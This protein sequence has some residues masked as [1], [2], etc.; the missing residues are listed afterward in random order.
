[1]TDVFFALG[2]RLGL[3]TLVS[4]IDVLPRQIRWDAM[5]RAALRDEVL[6]AQAELTAAVVRDADPGADANALA[7]AW[8]ARNPALPAR[9]ATLREVCEG[10]PTLARMS[11]GLGVV[12]GLV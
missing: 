12:R 8:M 3:D 2:E 11:V 7:E 9:I 6:E 5:A 4:R 1:M 10:D